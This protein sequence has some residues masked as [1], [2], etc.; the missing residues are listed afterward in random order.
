ML[1]D[2]GADV[3]AT[4]KDGK[5]VLFKAK[6]LTNITTTRNTVKILIDVGA[7]KSTSIIVYYTF[8]NLKRRF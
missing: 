8:A 2:A 6:E 3:N 1:I 7:N 5:T 4:D